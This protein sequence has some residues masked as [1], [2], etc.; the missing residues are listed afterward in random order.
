MLLTREAGRT[1]EWLK[2]HGI[3]FLGPFLENPD[4]LPRMHNVIPSARTYISTLRKVAEKLGVSIL[5]DTQAIGLTRDSKRITGVTAQDL[6]TGQKLRLYAR[7]GVILA[8]GD[9]SANSEMKREFG[10]PDLAEVDPINPLSTGDGHRIA[11]G[12][13]AAVKNMSAIHAS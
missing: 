2:G 4:R 1:I 3:V 6:R 7:R 8:T 9:F 11:V 10:N 12:A 13:G 5:L